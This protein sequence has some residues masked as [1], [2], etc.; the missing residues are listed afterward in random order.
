MTK[1]LNEGILNSK[2][3]KEYTRD[4]L[5][6]LEAKLYKFLAQND[7]Y[8]EDG[9]F[10]SAESSLYD[11]DLELLIEG[12]WKH[13]HWFTETLVEQFCKDNGL[14]IIR[15][16]VE[17]VGDSDS[18]WYKGWHYWKLDTADETS[19]ERLQG[20]R[21]FFN[22]GKEKPTDEINVLFVVYKNDKG[23]KVGDYVEYDIDKDAFVDMLKDNEDV[24]GI[25]DSCTNAGPI[26][27]IW[28]REGLKE[29]TVKQG[30]YWVNKGKEG[31]HGKFKTKKAADAQRRA[32]W[33]NWDK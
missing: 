14:I 27:P 15:H 3:K 21:K 4:E 28:E 24:I 12:D 25:Y 9:T 11:L 10:E 13:D 30:K 2:G 1:K 20:F 18:D 23:E 31:T 6:T 22:E 7:I 33:V 32:I 26:G 5:A 16:D 29:D 17:E 8:P 19:E